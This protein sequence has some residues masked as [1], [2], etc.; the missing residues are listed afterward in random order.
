MTMINISQTNHHRITFNLY[1]Q[2]LITKILSSPIFNCIKILTIITHLRPLLAISLLIMTH[3]RIICLGMTHIAI[4]LLSKI[5]RY[6]IWSI[7]V[8]IIIIARLLLFVIVV[9]LLPVLTFVLWNSLSMCL[10]YGFF[11]YILGK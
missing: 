1:S 6:C 7:I 9:L 8:I 11:F 3:L 5:Q 10:R 2:M 4:E